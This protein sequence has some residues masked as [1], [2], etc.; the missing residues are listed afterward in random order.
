MVRAL[1]MIVRLKIGWCD[2]FLLRQAKQLAA[3]SH[4]HLAVLRVLRL[5]WRIKMYFVNARVRY[6]AQQGHLVCRA[7]VQIALQAAGVPE[8][9]RAF[10]VRQTLFLQ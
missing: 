6:R 5:A 4:H 3:A 7:S 9:R 8:E 2:T 10:S 1:M